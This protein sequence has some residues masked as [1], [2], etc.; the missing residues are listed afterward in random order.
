MNGGFG[1]NVIAPTAPDDRIESIDAIRGIALF[2]VLIVNLV[3]AFRVS[4]FQQFIGTPDA[5]VER[6]VAAGLEEKAFS[7]F[8][9]LFGVGLAMQFDRLC[10]LGRPLYWLARRLAVLLVFGLVHLLLV[11]NGDILTEY[12]LAGLVALP[13]LRLRSA[14]LL[15]A[16]FGFLVLHAVGPALYPVPWPDP[17]ALQRHVA[18]ANQVYSTGSLAEIRRFSLE[19]LPLFLS[20]HI[21]VF[22]RTLALFAFGMFLWRAGILRRAHDFEDELVVAALAGIAA[23]VALTLGSFRNLGIVALALGYG[24]GLLALAQ[25]SITRRFVSAFAPMGR[26][27]FTNYV[28]QSIIF[29]FIF[30]GYGLGQFGRM[31]AATAFAI[32]VAVYGAQLALSQRWL[33]RYRFGPIE[34]LW[35]TLMYGAAQ[36]MNKAAPRA[37]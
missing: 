19:E 27:A 14:G 33:R 22:P 37:G 6:I 28:M 9:L 21:F 4:I 11:W 2:G 30:F 34:W 18:L 3:T 12:A 15:L 20:L 32:G 24:A 31:G 25:L 29:G 16:A 1:A 10:A 17:A 36:P 13:L 35:R 5:V 23:G 26:M 8:A 7:L